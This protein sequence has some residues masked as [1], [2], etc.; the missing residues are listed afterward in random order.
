MANN[1]SP[2]NIP[3]DL[4][5]ILATFHELAGQNGMVAELDWTEKKLSITGQIGPNPET[6][7]QENK[8]KVMEFFDKQI[9][10]KVL[11]LFDIKL[12]SHRV[13]DTGFRYEFDM[14]CCVPEQPYILRV[15]L[16]PDRSGK[17]PEQYQ[18]YLDWIRK[19]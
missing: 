5:N 6:S 8:K 17:S 16:H 13:A 3:S 9:E 14:S 18:K 19:E 1:R 12:S 11:N 15:R 4:Q 7:D 2:P 10:S